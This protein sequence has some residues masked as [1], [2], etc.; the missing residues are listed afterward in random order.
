MTTLLFSF[1]VSVEEF[2]TAQTDT[3]LSMVVQIEK[4]PYLIVK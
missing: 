3:S 1:W 2:K 4:L